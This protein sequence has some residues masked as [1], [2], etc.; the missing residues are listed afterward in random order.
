MIKIQ[1]ICYDDKSSYEKGAALAPNEIRKALFSPSTN[2]FAENGDSIAHLDLVNT[3]DHEIRNYFEIESLTAG[4]LAEGAN[5]LSLGGDHSIT[6]PII[7]A[8]KP[9]YPQLD[10]LHLDAHA[11]LYEEFEGD[12]YSH[13]CPFARIMEAGLATRL[14]Q[15]GIRTLTDEQRSQAKKYGVEIHEIKDWHISLLPEFQ[16]PVYISLDMDVFDPSFAPGV[17]HYEPGGFSARQVLDILQNVQA[18]IIGAD[19]VEYNPRKDHHAMTAFLAAKMMKE[20]VVRM[21]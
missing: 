8:L 21:G 17:S 10:I 5:I 2:L 1:G 20:I 7:K 14:V 19:I 9:H 12:R 13:A 15:V 11:D 16:H 18:Q 3:G 6:Y 4:H